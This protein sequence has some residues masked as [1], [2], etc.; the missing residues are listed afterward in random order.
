MADPLN[1]IGVILKVANSGAAATTSWPAL[2]YTLLKAKFDTTTIDQADTMRLFRDIH[3]AI[4]KERQDGMRDAS[5]EHISAIL[6]LA[7][8]KDLPDPKDIDWI[9][10]K[11]WLEMENPGIEIPDSADWLRSFLR[12]CRNISGEEVEQDIPQHAAQPSRFE[13]TLADSSYGSHD[14]EVNVA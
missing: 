4:E 9:M 6:R 3:R 7:N 10:L 5:R 14:S 12:F 13:G 1:H 8:Q 11:L 2:K